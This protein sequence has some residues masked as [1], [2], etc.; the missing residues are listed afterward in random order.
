MSD[1]SFKTKKWGDIYR[2]IY[3]GKQCTR[4]QISEQLSISLPT[5][6]HCLKQ[7]V[8]EGLVYNWGPHYAIGGRK[9][10][11]YRCVADY[12]LALGID[13]TKHHLSLVLIDLE[14]RIVDKKRIRCVFSDSD[15]YF[16]HLSQELK[17]I[18]VKNCVDDG[19]LL[20]VGIS[21]PVIVNA[22]QRSISYAEVIQ[23]SDNI[24]ER[25]AAHI[26]Y[27]FLLFNDANSA[28]LAESWVSDTS[29]DMT[30]LFL[31]GSVGG[32]HMTGKQIQ[33]GTNQRGGEFGHMCII[34]GGDLC[35]CGQRGCLDAYCSAKNLSDLTGGN[36][37]TFFEELNLGEN[38]GFQRV[39]DRYT[40]Y[41]ALAVKNLRMCYDS[42]I[43]LGGAVGSYMSDHIDGFRCKVAALDPFEKEMGYIRVCHYKTEASAVGSAIYYVNEFIEGL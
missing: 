40:D 26:P 31:G 27:P 1:K 15:A 12:R 2:A 41:L 19:R 7:L 8:D 9:A 34:P 25:M 29:N 4:R 20:G 22:D 11:L 37:N 10:S 5:V 36:L 35:Y 38:L 30:Y 28:G 43:V 18:L 3:T 32:A 23:V 33:Y 39:F 13:I 16:T 24:Y 14:L 21:M 17:A 6:T 42:D